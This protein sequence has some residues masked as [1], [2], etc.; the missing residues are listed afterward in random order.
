MYKKY[1]GIRRL[2]KTSE[3]KLPAIEK[4]HGVI[5]NGSQLR[6]VQKFKNL[7]HGLYYSIHYRS[8][9][10]RT[11]SKLIQQLEILAYQSRSNHNLDVIRS[12]SVNGVYLYPP[13]FLPISLMNFNDEFLFLTRKLNKQVLF[14]L[15][16]APAAAIDVSCELNESRSQVHGRTKNR[17]EFDIMYTIFLDMALERFGLINFSVH[18]HLPNWVEWGDCKVA[19]NKVKFNERKMIFRA[20]I[21]KVVKRRIPR[22]KILKMAS[23]KYVVEWT[24]KPRKSKLILERFDLIRY[25]TAYYELIERTGSLPTAR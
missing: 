1:D 6:D 14:Y 5:D 17:N 7:S 13:F 18:N 11:R 8:R 22:L 25:R 2:E 21:D 15:A 3:K 4:G 19:K 23:H 16:F 10:T 12:L 20:S 24:Q 9:A